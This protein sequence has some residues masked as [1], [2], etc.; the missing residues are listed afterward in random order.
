VLIGAINGEDMD[1]RLPTYCKALEG[2]K[3]GDSV[4]Y[5]VQQAE[6]APERLSVPLGGAE[7]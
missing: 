6:R 4:D 1:G 5:L 3:A 2:K 7:S